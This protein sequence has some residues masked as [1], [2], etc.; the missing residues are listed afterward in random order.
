MA[1]EGRRAAVTM[2]LLFVCMF[3][4]QH[5]LLA[6]TPTAPTGVWSF[7]PG[8]MSSASD[9]ELARDAWDM[10]DPHPDPNSDP[11]PDPDTHFNTRFLALPIPLHLIF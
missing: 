11:D 2:A 7:L 10:Y 1:K 4:L 9:E 3:W 8:A 5:W 6:L